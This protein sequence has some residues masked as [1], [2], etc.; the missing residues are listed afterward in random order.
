[1]AYCEIIDLMIGDL[2]TSAALD[3]Q[4]YVNDA[5]DEIDSKIGFVYTTPIPHNITDATP[6]PVVLL[7]KRIN[8][9]LATGRMI[10]AATLLAEDK[11]LNAYGQALVNDS[12]IAI[13]QIAAGQMILDGVLR[14]GLKAVV[15][16]TPMILN[17]D[18][19]SSVDAFYDRVVNP[20]YTY[21]SPT[22]NPLYY[23]GLV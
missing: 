15:A 23:K 1:M 19:E 12:E 9:H 14:S 5:A 7:L 10:L 22:Y 17:K 11:Q 3:P 16:H 20:N 18:S 21:G 13:S 8:A 4:K 6:R 2:P